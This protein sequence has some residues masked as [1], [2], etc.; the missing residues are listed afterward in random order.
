MILL[1]VDMSDGVSS[2][3]SIIDD[4]GFDLELKLVSLVMILIFVYV[5]LLLKWFLVCIQKK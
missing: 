1:T 2:I 5:F 3:G 4:G